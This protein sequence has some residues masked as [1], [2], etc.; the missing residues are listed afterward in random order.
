MRAC[1]QACIFASECVLQVRECRR[2]R[3][4]SLCFSP[5]IA[6]VRW[7]VRER[8]YTSALVRADFRGGPAMPEL[9]LAA[10]ERTL[11]IGG[12]AQP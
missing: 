1:A 10:P 7:C 5:G 8:T 2:G 11:E 9:R 12:S 4:R 6:G 3:E